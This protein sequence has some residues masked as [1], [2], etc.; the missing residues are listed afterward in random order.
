[1]KGFDILK[2]VNTFYKISIMKNNYSIFIGL[3]LLFT[4]SNCSPKEYPLGNFQE[5]RIVADGNSI[6]WNLPLRFGSEDG[7]L[8]YNITNDNT[9]IYVSVATSDQSTQMRIL[10]A[11]LS[12]YIDTKGKTN[13]SMGLSF[14]A[15]DVLETAGNYKTRGMGGNKGGDQINFKKQLLMDK[16]IFKTFG[17]INMDNRVYDVSDT[18]AIKLGINYDAF[19]NLVFEAIIPI[20]HIYNKT[21]TAKNAPSLS[22]GIVL[23]TTNR[24]ENRP[25]AGGEGRSEGG[26]RGGSGGGM[27]GMG[28]GMGGG[29]MRGG[30]GM[31]GMGGGMRGGGGM[32]AGGGGFNTM[33]KVIANWYQ[34]KLAF[35]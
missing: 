19:G 21:F 6:D 24:S 22:V 32:R 26:M 23:N 15:N 33:N 12:V 28:G 9:N 35:Q 34:C 29:G 11:G 18:T 30:G 20:K 10:R 3:L 1:L 4:L 31:G 17:F 16:D 8:Q 25:T 27:G 5:T 13:K 7:E 2:A 14:P